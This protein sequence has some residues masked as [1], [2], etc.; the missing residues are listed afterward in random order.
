MYSRTFAVE[1][2]YELVRF[3]D[4]ESVQVSGRRWRA[5]V[6]G[7]AGKIQKTNQAPKKG[8]F[9]HRRRWLGGGTSDRR[10]GDGIEVVR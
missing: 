4:D 5:A 1:Q 10:N 7:W 2:V 6:Q 8:I 9:F 3:D